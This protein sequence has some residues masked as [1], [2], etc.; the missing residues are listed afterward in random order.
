MKWEEDEIDFMSTALE[1]G[2]THKDIANELGRTLDAIKIKV[3][4]MSLRS[5][6]G[7]KTTAEYRK[8]LPKDI[9][10]LEKYIKSKIKI[11]HKHSCGFEWKIAPN[12]ILNGNGCP[13]CSRKKTTAKYINQLP[14]D[15]ILL[16]KYI[17]AHT[18]ILH[19]HSCGFEW[20][21]Q[22]TSILNGH[23]C[24][25]CMGNIK[26]TTTEYVNQLPSD[27]ILLEP[28]INSGNKILHKH[29]C[30]YE[31]K[32]SPNN[33]LSGNSC[34][35]CA[36]YGFKPDISAVTYCIYFKE[37]DLYKVGIS[38]KYKER[39]KTFGYK[40][41]IIFMREFRLGSEA[42]E[43]EIKW[44]QNIKDYKINTGLLMSGNTETFRI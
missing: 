10:V 34:P 32:I 28:Y 40:P 17:N 21:I 20:E 12:S 16:S 38:N 8:Q 19:R 31:W 5:L 42:K 3:S 26:K 22:P 41:E 2:W 27:I 35:K 24:P 29:S 7:Q 44:L 25:K 37:L 15:I 6:N 18:K 4:R 9:K 30:G 1:E 43:L 11:L 13:N 39:M 33:I 23:S 36:D 14:K